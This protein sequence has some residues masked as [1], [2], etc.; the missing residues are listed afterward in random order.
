M[1]KI[2]LLLLFLPAV[3]RA[4]SLS[5]EELKRCEATAARVT[6]LRDNWGIP[7]IYGKTDADAVFGLL[8]TE[9]QEDFSRVEK[10]YLEMLGRQAEAYGEDYL[11]TDLTMRLIYDSAAAM[12]DY[13]NS[14]PWMHQLLDAFA[15]GVNYYLHKHPQ[16]HPAVL[17]RFEPWFP[18]MFTDGSVNATSTGGIRPDEVKALYFSR[19]DHMMGSS[20]VKNRSSAKDLAVLEQGLG[21]DAERETGSNGFAIAPSHT[22]SGN[23]LLYINP[24]VP[25][26]FRLEA[27][28]VSEEGLN[29]YGAVTWGQF[30]I[31][32][33]FNEHCGWMHTSSYADVADAY[34][35]HIGGGAGDYHY[36]YAGR[37][38][39]VK[40]KRFTLAYKKD[41]GRLSKTITGYFTHH[42]PVM[43]MRDGK[44]LSL[45]EKNRSLSALEEAWLTTKA[46]SFAEYKKAMDLRSNTTNNTVYADDQGNI[47]YWHGNFMPRRDPSFD[48]SLPV[49]GATPATEWKGVHALDEIVHVYNPSSGWIQNCNATPFTV[50]GA[51]SPDKRSYPSY[52]AP[53]G[54]NFRGVHAVQLLK[55]ARGWTLDSL[56]AKG[57]DR[58]L[59]AFDRLVPALLQAYAASPDSLRA[60]LEEPVSLLQQWD[61]RCDIHSVATTLAVEWAAR[62]ARYAPRPRTTEEGS[63]A[64][65]SLDSE[66]VRSTATEKLQELAAA[67]KDLQQR[68]GSWKIEWGEVNRYQ[69]LTG[70]IAETYNDALPSLPSG[71]VSSAFGALPSYVSRVMK[72][73][74]KR[75]GYSGN[76]FIAAVEFGKKVKAKTLLTGGE[77]SDPASPHFSDQAAM[78]LEGRFK[79][80][81]FY[82]ED[83][84][85]N[86]VKS[87]HPGEE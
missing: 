66:L 21:E 10:N 80:V 72:D 76:S 83:V 40:S 31:Y 5:A 3:S 86:K 69:R 11:S 18:L 58:Y 20:G 42:G 2:L 75:Y 43:G 37:K 71:L 61:R 48:W 22:A 15:D 36:E 77:S 54:E 38:L 53:D 27:Q 17:R 59:S 28:L 49:N 82:T 52:M 32:Q 13:R 14:P 87:Y 47:A 56:I 25:F 8:Y 85:K 51:S 84:Q 70:K 67:V 34:E 68:Y 46:N 57:Y 30:F 9:C 23:A 4:Q 33:G 64:V 79:D 74:K 73:T 19:K 44:F 6:I 1:R 41:E 16:T 55:D 29:A 78:Y 81:S 63:N 24:H 26:Y 7:H 12:A 60:A 45:K 39:P 35:E 50:S 62:L 65:A